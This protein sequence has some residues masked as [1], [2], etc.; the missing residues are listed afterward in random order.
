MVRLEPNLRIDLPRVAGYE[1]LHSPR[2]F[3]HP[4]LIPDAAL[5]YVDRR[6]TF[7]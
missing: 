4:L 3:P 1:F 5:V 2:F 6:G 7:R